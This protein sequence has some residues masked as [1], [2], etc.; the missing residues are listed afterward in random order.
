MTFE[1]FEQNFRKKAIQSGFSEDNIHKCLVYAE[2]LINK[3]LPVIFNT[4]NLSALV[5]YKKNFI[6]KAAL[7]TDY[8]YRNFTILKKNGKRRP[9]K[10]P[11]PSLKEIQ[12]WI[13]EN[14]LY[15]IPV[16][17]Y[18]KAY[19]KKRNLLDN[20][21]YHKDKEIVI[22]L[23]IKDFFPSIKRGSIE[24]IFLELGYSS[25]ISNLLGKLCCCN[26]HLPQGAPTS[27]YLSNIYMRNFDLTL[28][29]YCN[30]ENV[31][32]TRYADD[33]TLSGKIDPIV[34]IAFVRK[35]LLAYSLFLNEEK[36]KVMG[37]NVR[38]I[39]TG[40]VVN[41]KIQIPKNYRDKIRQEVYFIKKFGLANHL[42][43]INS[44]QANYVYH[45]IGKINFALQINPLD[46]DMIDYRKFIK[47]LLN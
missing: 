32:Y 15:T 31:R 40:I 24:K 42:Q 26:D 25:N 16:S 30:V 33:I 44:S 2:P 7:Y 1:Y 20:V 34:V 19:V 28:S 8:F 22:T 14:I 5:G 11:L 43:K 39:V 37:K 17:K 47:G 35:E 3:G 38:Q 23:D 4:A 18:A 9:L 36:I 46:K 27:P 45:L 21:K 12:C 10:E 41:D 29:N 13:L 6:K